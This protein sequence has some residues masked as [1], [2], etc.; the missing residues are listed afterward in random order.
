MRGED[1]DSKVPSDENSTGKSESNQNE[2]MKKVTILKPPQNKNKNSLTTQNQ[3]QKETESK[4][5]QASSEK[6]KPLKPPTE[7]LATEKPQSAKPLASNKSEEK[8]Q[9]VSAKDFERIQKLREFME[10]Q[11]LNDKGASSSQNEKDRKEYLNKMDQKKND[12]KDSKDFKSGSRNQRNNKSKGKQLSDNQKSDNQSK[13]RKS[14]P[15]SKSSSSSGMRKQT[16]QPQ[17]ES[18]GKE[19]A[20][21]KP[22]TQ[23]N[24]STKP[25]QLSKTEGPN[26]KSSQ[27]RSGKDVTQHVKKVNS[28][29]QQ[30]NQNQNNQRP[31]QHNGTSILGNPYQQP[32]HS[33]HPSVNLPPYIKQQ[34]QQQQHG[35]VYPGPG[36]TSM[37][38]GHKPHITVPASKDKQ[39]HKRSLDFVK[40]FF[41]TDP[42]VQYNRQKNAE[43]QSASISSTITPT[44]FPQTTVAQS[45]SSGNSYIPNSNDFASYLSNHYQQA[46]SS[47]NHGANLLPQNI[48][49]PMSMASNYSNFAN[50]YHQ[51]SMTANNQMAAHGHSSHVT[52]STAYSQGGSTTLH[53]QQQQQHRSSPGPFHTIGHGSMSQTQPSQQ[54]RNFDMYSSINQNVLHHSQQ[55]IPGSLFP[56]R[57]HATSHSSNHPSSNYNMNS[58]SN[59]F[60][61]GSPHSHILHAQQEI[62]SSAISNILNGMKKPK[63]WQQKALSKCGPIDSIQARSL[64][65]ELID[66]SYECMVCCD[67]IKFNNAVWS[68]SS[69]FHIFHLHCIRK[70]AKS[71]AAAVKGQNGW[72][73]PG[74]QNISTRPPNKYFCFCG[75][76]RDPDWTPRDGITPH[77]CGEVCKKKRL[78]PPCDHSCNELCHPGP[79]PS[80]PVMVTRRCYCGKSSTKVRCGS[81]N[82]ITCDNQCSKVLECGQHHCD[83]KCHEGACKKCEVK[84]CQECFC[85]REKRVIIC[86]T[87]EL[88]PKEEYE[89]ENVVLRQKTFSCKELCGR[90][91]SCGNHLCEDPCHLGECKPCSLTPD[92]VLSCPCKKVEIEVLLGEAKRTSC[93]DPVPTCDSFCG[94]K[95]PCGRQG[96]THLCMLKC[97]EGPCKPCNKTVEMKCRCNATKKEMACKDMRP[98]EVLLC[99]RKCTKKRKCGRHKCNQK[100]CID[101]EHNCNI[102]CG[103]KLSCGQHK[104]D[105]VCH[106]GFCPTCWRAGFDELSCYC[107]ATVLDPP[108]PCGAKPPECNQPCSRHHPCGHA[109]LHPCHN[110][111][112]CPPCAVLTNK[113]CMGG[114]QVWKNIPCH[115]EEVSCGQKCGKPLKCGMHTCNKFCHKGDCLAEGE[116]CQQKCVLPRPSCT[117][118][119]NAPCHVGFKCPASTCKSNITITC[120]CRRKTANALCMAGN[121]QSTY[122]S[123]NAEI[124]NMQLQNLQSG[125]VIDISSLT[126]PEKRPKY[127]ECDEE[128]SRIER[129]KRLVEAL[130]IQNPE[131]G[132]FECSIYPESLKHEARL[133]LGFIQNLETVFENLYLSVKKSSQQQMVHNF[134]PMPSVQRKIIHELAECY[135]FK[136]YSVDPEP[137]RSTVVI[138]YKES[139]VPQIKLSQLISREVKNLVPSSLSRINMPEQQENGEKMTLKSIL[140]QPSQPQPSSIKRVNYF[141]DNLQE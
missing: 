22:V 29:Y 81:N 105:E 14:Q 15:S 31:P 18:K 74:C 55:N 61:S 42:E 7:K 104:C 128:C 113:T 112:R 94:K 60:T 92:N 36:P 124:L 1:K 35:H 86:G 5:Q 28:N 119:C 41:D 125:Q 118:L 95:L 135:G 39:E 52:T 89:D 109:P 65:K 75:K 83:G 46:H 133:R 138:A 121:L 93:L 106:A 120:R 50:F 13:E 69:C 16:Q 19:K 21:E 97:H 137:K 56:V 114:H 141:D 8:P 99:D 102:I 107:G 48:P 11:Q 23:Q 88:V 44:S 33:Q 79:C 80:C 100:C 140:K 101:K 20:K 91:L 62:D 72:R 10:Q 26:D 117:H 134:P 122:Q 37:I 136:T 78:N 96:A 30:R 43:K 139:Y 126:N 84:L 131:G 54:Q 111:E 98:D 73:C 45:A 6:P 58:Y 9:G 90:V 85:A 3:T 27:Q 53:Q 57:S 70:W 129:N 115:Q 38:K 87:G 51:S 71:E 24:A 34:Q 59:Y 17:T 77:S 127:L 116:S 76:V 25:K 123:F 4:A 64:I 130:G 67:T 82:P 40:K 49:L 108:T 103:K 32:H 132:H 12:K 68:C 2:S 66:G 63:K 47:R 110:E